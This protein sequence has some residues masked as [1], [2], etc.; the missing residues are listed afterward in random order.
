VVDERKGMKA[1]YSGDGVHPNVEGYK[2]ME[3][4]VESAIRKALHQEN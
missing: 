1:E 2:V 4:L 3:P